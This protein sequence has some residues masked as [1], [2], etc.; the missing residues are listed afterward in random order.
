MQK[1]LQTNV[2]ETSNKD[3][4]TIGTIAQALHSRGDHNISTH[5]RTGKMKAYTK[6][7]EGW[8]TYSLTLYH[9]LFEYYL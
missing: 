7:Y 3:T 2:L 9:L 4:Q 6:F 1:G 8:R 5:K